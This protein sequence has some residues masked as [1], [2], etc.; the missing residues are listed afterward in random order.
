MVKLMVIV[1]ACGTRFE[2]PEEWFEKVNGRAKESFD[3]GGFI[4]RSNGIETHIYKPLITHISYREIDAKEVK[5]SKTSKRKV[6]V[7]K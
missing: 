6:N 4:Y 7:K 5:S 2:G 1:L 3:F